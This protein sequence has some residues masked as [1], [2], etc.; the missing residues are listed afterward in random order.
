MYVRTHILRDLNVHDLDIIFRG[1]VC[2]S[3]FI[4]FELFFL[5]LFHSQVNI[6]RICEKQKTKRFRKKKV[7]SV[8]HYGISDILN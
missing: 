2:V 8:T 7:G 3:L 4:L 1:G 5:T 6:L